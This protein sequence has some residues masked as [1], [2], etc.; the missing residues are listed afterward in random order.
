MQFLIV[1]EE[2]DRLQEPNTG[3]QAQVDQLTQRSQDMWPTVAEANTKTPTNVSAYSLI[4]CCDHIQMTC[5]RLAT[6]NVEMKRKLETV[7]SILPDLVE[8]YACSV[9]SKTRELETKKQALAN[10]LTDGYALM[11]KVHDWLGNL[12]LK[13]H[14]VYL[15]REKIQSLFPNT[16]ACTDPAQLQQVNEQID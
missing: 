14:Q 11:G 6:K 1:T 8:I 7:R 3:L 16:R 4:D 13:N 2:F 5:I 15:L 9:E 10:T 12:A